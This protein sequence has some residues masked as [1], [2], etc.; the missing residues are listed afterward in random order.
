MAKKVRGV[1][2]IKDDVYLIDYQVGG[3]EGR[4][5]PRIHAA[6]MSEARAE[7]E[8]R[9][10]ELRERLKQVPNG[11]DRLNAT[12]E[13]AWPKIEESMKAEGVS[14]K[15]TKRC[16]KIFW[17]IFGKFLP[18]KYPFITS[19]SLLSLQ[20]FQ[21]YH[22][23]FVNDLKRDGQGGWGKDLGHIKAMMERLRRAG[24]CGREILEE[25]RELP[26]PESEK[27]PFHMVS[28]EQMKQLL[29]VIKKEKPHF[30]YPC[31]HMARTGRRVSE[32]LEVEKRDV[33]WNGLNPVGIRIRAVTTKETTEAPIDMLDEDLA[34][35]VKETIRRNHNLKTEYLFPS[36]EGHKVKYDKLR[37]YLEK[38]SLSILGRAIT[39]HYFRKRVL[40]MCNDN[41]ISHAAIMALTG[42]R[43]YKVMQKHYVYSTPEGLKQALDVT[44]L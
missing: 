16:K 27:T 11:Q 32:T 9:K 43:D 17:T 10:V 33:I 4:H 31:Y 23:Y 44:R 30:Y 14:Q 39:P 42:L 22:S 13:M 8:K 18:L 41:R 24:F 28:K 5:Q 38:T 40:T 7:R 1:K 20:F 37:K 6:S 2:H 25:L 3:K 12:F 34:Q 15:Y 21:D 26:C 19:P 35:A 36:P 29:D